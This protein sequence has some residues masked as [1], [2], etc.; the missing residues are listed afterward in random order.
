MLRPFL[1]LLSAARSEV[2]RQLVTQLV[3][4]TTSDG[5]ISLPLAQDLLET[6]A[7]LMHEPALGLKA[8]LY[9]EIGDFAVLEW[10]CMSAATCREASETACR[11]IRILNAA[12][13]YRLA[14]CDSKAHLM[15]GST[16]PLNRIVTDYQIAAYH[17]ALR[18]RVPEVPPELEV[19]LKHAEPSDI[20][21]YRV[22]FPHA[23]LVFGAA[24]N[25]F[26]TD[27]WRLDTPLPTAN[28]SLHEV[29]RAHANHLLAEL[30]PGDGLTERVS[31][32]I[33]AALR[34]SP[35]AV[36]AERTAARLGFTRRTFTRQLEQQGTTFSELLKEARYRTAVH[37]LG[38]SDHTVEEIAFLLGFSECS[39]FAHAFRRWS[40][41]TPLAYRR[42]YRRG[43]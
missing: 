14:I 38:H 26:V 34:V 15:L 24:F 13:D 32:D 33:L 28:E 8:A 25:G 21:E 16:I 2:P 41:V 30:A 6:A 22:V 19:W 10:V 3:N 42:A 18:L 11:Y 36:T 23:K 35:S 27:A 39:A 12:A 5:R 4:A 31:A 9:T 29:L 20:S 37:Y 43:A 1:K 17:L 40:G 7:Q